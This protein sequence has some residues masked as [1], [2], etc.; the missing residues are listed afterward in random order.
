ML[1]WKLV[2]IWTLC[3]STCWLSY[4]N[5]ECLNVTQHN[6]TQ[7]N[8]TH[9][10]V[11][12]HSR[13]S[14]YDVPSGLSSMSSLSSLSWLPGHGVALKCVKTGNRLPGS[15]LRTVYLYYRSCPTSFDNKLR[16]SNL[17]NCLRNARCGANIFVK[18]WQTNRICCLTA[19]HAFRSESHIT[20]SQMCGTQSVW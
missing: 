2:E 13:I 1:I 8:T 16:I 11:V 9:N 3:C 4:I 6:S 7:P 12:S 15:I 10:Q 19:C 20:A 14:F 5:A 18:P 17:R